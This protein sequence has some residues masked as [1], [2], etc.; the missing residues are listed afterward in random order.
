MPSV[1]PDGDPVPVDGALPQAA[2]ASLQRRPLSV[3][4]HVPFCSVRCGYC[5]FNTYTLTELGG[6][7]AGI[8]TY[9]DAVLAELDLAQQVLGADGSEPPSV[10]T[11]FVGGGTP[12]MLA[13]DDLVRMLD[14]IRSRFG[15]TADAEITTEANPDTIDGDVAATG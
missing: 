7:G 11:V 13:T 1:L 5:D 9:A 6:R 14:G 10:S 4:V 8:S 3:Y 12:T 2:L 15:L